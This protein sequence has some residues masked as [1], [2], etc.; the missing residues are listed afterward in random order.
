MKKTRKA[1]AA[2]KDTTEPKLRFG[3]W[4]YAAAPES[5][6]HFE[7]AD[8]YELFVGGE[9][10]APDG[11][12]H[13]ATVNPASEEQLS[14]VAQAGQA[15]VDRA[16]KAARDALPAWRALS[17][18]QRGRYLY[19][20]ARILQERAR[21]FACLETLDGG[22]PIREA[23][24]VDVPL[25]AA[26][27]FLSRGL[28]RQARPR[29]PRCQAGTDRRGRPGDPVELSA[30]DGGVEDRARARLR[31]HRRVEGLPRPRR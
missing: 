11:G 8:R 6:D 9:F 28:G 29:V 24:D 17:G 26:H 7:I 4:T 21:E 30:A 10:V 22:K 19:R 5:T 15:D 25:A 2:D 3:S 13:F 18:A 16:V 1:E 20:I 23:R 14:E 27:F 31:Q 12:A